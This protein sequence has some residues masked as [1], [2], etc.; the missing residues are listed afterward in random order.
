MTS[1]IF[2]WSPTWLWLKCY[3][4]VLMGFER[5][6]IKKVYCD[7]KFSWKRNTYVAKTEGENK[8]RKSAGIRIVDQTRFI[9]LVSKNSELESLLR[10]NG[11]H[12][13]PLVRAASKS[14]FPRSEEIILNEG[15]IETLIYIFA[16]WTIKLLAPHILLCNKNDLVKD[17]KNI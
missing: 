17:S 7:C 12:V 6:T 2:R 9:Y 13:L 5:I 15:K 8:G 16:S 11:Q 3:E 14:I 10:I 4:L 1:Y